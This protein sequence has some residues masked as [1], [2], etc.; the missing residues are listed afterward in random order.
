MNGFNRVEVLGNVGKAPEVRNTK[1]GSLMASFSLATTRQWKD[2][3]SGETRKETTWIPCTAFGR[4][5]EIVEKYVLKG[6]PLYVSGHWQNDQYEKNGEK[7]TF[8]KCIVDSLQLLSSGKRDESGQQDNG[9]QRQN[10]N[11]QARRGPEEYSDAYE[12]PPGG[13]DDFPLDFSEFDPS[14]NADDIDVPF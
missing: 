7:R 3:N 12:G 9:N 10:Y 4:T 2:K 13:D 14:F 5:A 1:N 8:T 6:M 11:N